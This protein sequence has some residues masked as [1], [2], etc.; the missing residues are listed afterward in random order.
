LSRLRGLYDTNPTGDGA[1]WVA[2]AYVSLGDA[3]RALT[4]LDR[5]IDANSS[6]LAYA[7]VDSRLD[8]LRRDPRFVARMNRIDSSTSS[9]IDE[10]PQPPVR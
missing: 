1:F 5:A 2:L 4:W 7:R 6:R 3:T 8:P 9:V 10:A